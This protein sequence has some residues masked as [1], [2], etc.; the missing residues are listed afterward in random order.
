MDLSAP[1][2]SGAATHNYNRAA[3]WSRRC[4]I[5][6]D[7]SVGF[8]SVART[9]VSVVLCRTTYFV[10][11]ISAAHYTLQSNFGWG[12]DEVKSLYPVIKVS[13]RLAR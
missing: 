10:S 11:L 5:N 9:V 4:K 13:L 3:L 1:R 12:D 6:I 8:C 7:L 2:V